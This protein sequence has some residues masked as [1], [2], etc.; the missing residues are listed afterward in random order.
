ML[1]APGELCMSGFGEHGVGGPAHSPSVLSQNPP[2]PFADPTSHHPHTQNP[3]L[4][5][6]RTHLAPSQ[7]PPL[8]PRPR[9][10]LS[11]TQNPPCPFPEPTWSLSQNS[12]LPCPRIHL[13]FVPEPS[14]RM[15]QNPPCLS[16]KPPLPSLLLLRIHI[17]CG[18][19][20]AFTMS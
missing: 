11:L 19:E 18:P 9:I 12:P 15:S 7:N 1:W 3:P 6:P 8:T 20:S 13:T 2:C 16:Q 17:Y 4:S 14:S 5:C 10:H